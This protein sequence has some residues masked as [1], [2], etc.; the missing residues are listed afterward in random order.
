MEWLALHYQW[1]IGSICIPIIGWV[2]AKK[3]KKSKGNKPEK[4]VQRND[5][6][7]TN[8]VTVNIDNGNSGNGE[9]R[10]PAIYNMA[11]IKDMV[12]I[13]FIDDERFNM[14]N[15]LKD[16][17]WRNVLYKKDVVNLQDKD[18]LQSHIIFV[19]IYGVG[20][21]LFKDQGKGLAGAL[22]DAYPNKKVILYSSENQG[23]MFDPTLRKVD[24]CLPKN[25]EP[26]EFISLVETFASKLTL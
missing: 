13:L 20:T 4:T 8:N 23:N 18:I 3:V 15:I 22:K 17:G 19:D 10:T 21:K 24:E 16:A 14:V 6:I 1:V 12:C 11:T 2:V 7:N 5:N 25:A 26:Y 9:N